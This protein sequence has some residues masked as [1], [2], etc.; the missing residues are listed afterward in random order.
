MKRPSLRRPSLPRGFSFT[1]IDTKLL[2]IVAI[3]AVSLGVFAAFAV[4]TLRIFDDSYELT[5]VFEETGDLRSG[6][7]VRLAGID[8]G[9]VTSVEPDFD[10]G[11]VVVGFDVD[12]GVDIGSRAT[13]EI[14]LATL[15]GGRYLRIAGPVEE[16]FMADLPAD[17]RRIPIERTRLPIGVTDALGDLSNTI[18]Q[19]DADAIDDLLQASAEVA[20][21]NAESFQPLFDDVVTLTETLNGRRQ[22]IDALLSSS[23]QLTDALASKDATIDR[24]VDSSARLLAELAA[25][26]DQIAT[27]LGTGSDAVQQL[28]AMVTRNRDSL[29]GLLRDAHVAGEVLA[30]HLPDLNGTLALLGPSLEQAG[31]AGESGPWLDAIVYG[32]SVAQLNSII[33]EVVRP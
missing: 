9:R 27:L 16:P 12:D 20:G 29:D 30:E 22:Q 33:D 6:D 11:V 25:R 8:V 2:G 7:A 23:A 3:A 26:R 31:L 19:I 17:E 10:Q 32:I 5:A 4:G 24:L 15:L 14:N 18:E 1:D 21:D 13:A 28:D